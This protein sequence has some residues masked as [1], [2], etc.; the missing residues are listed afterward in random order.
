ML[1]LISTITLKSIAFYIAS[2]GLTSRIRS[3]RLKDVVGLLDRGSAIPGM[4]R[5]NDVVAFS[6]T[7]KPLALGHALWY[8]P[9]EGLIPRV[10]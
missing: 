1:C 8:L 9:I 6:Q 10:A 2:D 3:S 5:A 7:I 4:S